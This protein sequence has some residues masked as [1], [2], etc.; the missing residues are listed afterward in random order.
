MF[1]LNDTITRFNQIH[2]KKIKLNENW[3]LF[4]LQPEG[5]ALLNNNTR[6]I[7][8]SAGNYP[9]FTTNDKG[10]HKT[11]VETKS[12]SVQEKT[13]DNQSDIQKLNAIQ[14]AFQRKNWEGR[15]LATLNDD[16]VW[17][18]FEEQIKS[19]DESFKQHFRQMHQN[20]NIHKPFQYHSS[21]GLL[22]LL[23]MIIEYQYHFSQADQELQ[24]KKQTWIPFA[25]IP[26][27]IAEEYESFLKKELK[28]FELFHKQVLDALLLRLKTVQQQ[29]LV[30]CDDVSYTLALQSEW[31][32][33]IN[34]ILPE[35][36]TVL[37]TNTFNDMQR[38]IEKH[39][40]ES[41]ISQLYQLAWYQDKNV[42]N[43][44]ELTTVTMSGS[45][46]LTP[47]ALLVFMSKKNK[48]WFW[49]SWNNNVV[50]QFL[51]K[52][53]ALLAQL[54]L[55][56]VHDR[57]ILKPIYTVYPELLT[58]STQYQLLQ[59]SR[60]SLKQQH[61]YWWQWEKKF[62]KKVW[63]EWLGQQLDTK[64]TSL[65]NK[66]NE[67]FKKAQEC[68]FQLQN[69]KFRSQVQVILGT[70]QALINEGVSTC[71]NEPLI[72]MFEYIVENSKAKSEE[73]VEQTQET[74]SKKNARVS[75]MVPGGSQQDVHT[76][77]SSF[78]SQPVNN[79]KDSYGK[80]MTGLLPTKFLAGKKGST[81]TEE[82][83]E[84]N[85]P[86]SFSRRGYQ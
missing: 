59:R 38:A 17:F 41:H 81:S 26:P 35:Y 82:K 42:G 49:F 14:V 83:P 65:L 75:P 7:R 13:P 37:D 72:K 61:L 47:N 19:K 45:R 62:W 39:G 24:Q 67:T 25:R 80:K 46:F 20:W 44:H 36:R 8:N 79:G 40:D 21:K 56:P 70:I 60:C 51:E 54:S 22:Y 63:Q 23:N 71:E 18:N 9:A 64:Q 77:E 66:L 57:S 16:Q 55:Q 48:K 30:T 11:S 76:A 31:I 85:E 29:G 28:K 1:N 32:N 50:L 86:A 43:S 68:E 2:R 69:V 12:Q 52:Q 74:T 73:G 27:F 4:Y 6:V 15:F 78:S 10:Q 58:L 33:F 5:L 3:G 84:I 53:Q 34:F